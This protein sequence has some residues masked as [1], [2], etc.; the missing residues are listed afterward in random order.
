MWG[1]QYEV[2]DY[3]NSGLDAN[4]PPPPSQFLFARGGGILGTRLAIT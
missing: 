4:P 2:R 1:V 3:V